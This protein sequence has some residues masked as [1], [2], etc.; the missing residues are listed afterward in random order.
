M[1][2]MQTVGLMLGL[3]GT[4]HAGEVSLGAAANFSATTRDLIPLFEKATGHT[5]KASFG[6]TGKLYSQ[7]AN[8]APFQVF[9]SADAKTPKK[10]EEEGLA[11]PGTRFTYAR[12]RLMLW[13][14]KP[15]LFADGEAYLK[16]G[17]LGRLAIANPGTAPYGLAAE[18]VLEHLGVWQG[19]QGRLVRGESI[20][21]TFQFAA[22]GNAEVAFVALS[23]LKAWKGDA[24]SSW[25]VPQTYYAP[26]DQQA[27]LLRKG[28][29]S[30][31]ARAFLAFLKGPEAR[32]VITH[33]GYGTE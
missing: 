2:V 14:A 29:H 23:Q 7:I 30:G 19:V 32:A 9:L 28:E 25:E 1:K 33:Y 8:G 20:S 11:V 24:G 18:Q 16:S 6:S 13:S 15:R 26:I 4:A 3:L 10:A 21:Q 31:A 17:V 22:T 27:V 5:V 12:G